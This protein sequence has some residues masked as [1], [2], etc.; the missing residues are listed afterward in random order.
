MNLIQWLLLRVQVW[1]LAR[2]LFE[3]IRRAGNP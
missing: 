1:L 2:R 3:E